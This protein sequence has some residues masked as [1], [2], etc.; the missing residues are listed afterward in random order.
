MIDK[1]RQYFYGVRGFGPDTFPNKGLIGTQ[2]APMK[3]GNYSAIIVYSRR[4]TGDE[5]KRNRLDLLD[6]ATISDRREDGKDKT[7]SE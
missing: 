4:L 2:K 6:I 1:E 5:C 3:W 7:V